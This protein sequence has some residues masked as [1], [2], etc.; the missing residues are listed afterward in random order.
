MFLGVGAKVVKVEKWNVGEKKYI[1]DP[2]AMK[3]FG[4]GVRVENAA[5]ELTAEAPK[6]GTGLD[7]ETKEMSVSKEM[8]LTV[9]IDP[10]AH[11]GCWKQCYRNY[12][13]VV[14]RWCQRQTS[15]SRCRIDPDGD[16]RGLP[17]DANAKNAL[18]KTNTGTYIKKGPPVGAPDYEKYGLVGVTGHQDN[19]YWLRSDD[20]PSGKKPWSKFGICVWEPAGG[21][22]DFR[23]AGTCKPNP[24][25]FN[26]DA[27]IP[28]QELEPLKKTGAELKKDNAA[29]VGTPPPATSRAKKTSKKKVVPVGAEGT[30]GASTGAT[31]IHGELEAS[32]STKV[33]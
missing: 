19:N 22:A 33:N 10:Q 11:K 16:L 9:V 26:E 8:R 1:E 25:F 17:L 6:G 30:K 2:E 7:I 13:M 3:P 29:L 12:Y 31:K 24:Y 4:P 32:P 15:L 5:K 28:G 14:N 20:G 27:K 21:T 18:R 23:S